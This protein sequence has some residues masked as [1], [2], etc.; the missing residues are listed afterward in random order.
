MLHQLTC[1]S[2]QM[3]NKVKNDTK[4]INLGKGRSARTREIQTKNIP[5]PVEYNNNHVVNMHF[6]TLYAGG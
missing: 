4:L 3:T 6:I 2:M 5:G 1:V